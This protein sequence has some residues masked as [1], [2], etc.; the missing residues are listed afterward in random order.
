MDGAA[1]MIA[2]DFVS[3]PRVPAL[4]S[5][6]GRPCTA[7]GGRSGP[8]AHGPS[9][10]PPQLHSPPP[11]PGGDGIPVSVGRVPRLIL[12]GPAQVTSSA[13]DQ[14]QLGRVRPSLPRP[15]HPPSPHLS[16]RGWGGRPGP[17]QTQVILQE[18]Q[19][20]GGQWR[21]DRPVSA[22]RPPAV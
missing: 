6:P 2:S 17:A 15:P 22:S 18:D 14:S 20:P 12:I 8:W 10:F 21:L 16:L 13:L 7:A 1:Q 19:D 5:I 9:P 3:Q 11:E 4:A